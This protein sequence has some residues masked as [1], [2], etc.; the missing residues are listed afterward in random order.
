MMQRIV[1]LLG[2]LLGLTSLVRSSSTPSYIDQV[3]SMYQSDVASL[4]DRVRGGDDLTEEERASVKKIFDEFLLAL[5]A[6]IIKADEEG[7]VPLEGYLVA[8][9]DHAQKNDPKAAV[10]DIF[11]GI[12]EAKDEAQVTSMGDT[13]A[14]F[15]TGAGLDPSVLQEAI[16]EVAQG[17]DKTVIGRLEEVKRKVA[18]AAKGPKEPKTAQ[19]DSGIDVLYAVEREYASRIKTPIPEET[20]KGMIKC[21]ENSIKQFLDSHP[22]DLRD[23][24]TFVKMP[25]Q[26]YLILGLRSL[27]LDNLPKGA[28][29]YCAA[30]ALEDEGTTK[31]QDICND[32]TKLSFTLQGLASYNLLDSKMLP[33]S[34]INEIRMYYAAVAIEI[35][36]NIYL[37]QWTD[38]MDKLQN[39]LRGKG[40]NIKFVSPHRRESG[41]GRDDDDDDYD[42]SA[43]SLDIH[44][45]MRHAIPSL[46]HSAAAA[47][48]SEAAEGTPLDKAKVKLEALITAGIPISI[49]S[50]TAEELG[51]ISNDKEA[52]KRFLP[53][54]QHE[55]VY[56]KR[57]LLKKHFCK[58]KSVKEGIKDMSDGDLKKAWLSVC[59]PFT[60]HMT[61]IIVI[62]G[63]VF[64]VLVAAITLYIYFRR[65]Q[66]TMKGGQL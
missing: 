51:L 9:V 41:S 42:P 5:G 24:R 58:G 16:K 18:E 37:H 40:F 44:H 53:V 15:V 29:F 43:D 66:S 63:I 59:R 45:I 61:M 14:R 23:M 2:I 21:I 48:S 32:L 28:L 11:M 13:L 65:S 39:Q 55:T 38:Y 6:S 7:D 8:A 31:I 30:A 33:I 64:S 17:K 3:S 20:K 25:P 50:L 12:A 56:A 10:R 52:A 19:E 62:I 49:D 22:Y 1:V 35:E 27:L 60:S 4:L 36:S 46:A 34:V 57:D 26:F 47:A 54:V